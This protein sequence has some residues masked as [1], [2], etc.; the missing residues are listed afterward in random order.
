M[1]L[2]M[3]VGADKKK[4]DLPVNLIYAAY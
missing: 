4:Q 3:P 1:A 2:T